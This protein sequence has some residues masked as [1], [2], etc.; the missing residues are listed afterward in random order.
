[1]AAI[2]MGNLK[3]N[4]ITLDKYK[5]SDRALGTMNIRS[6]VEKEEPIKGTEK[7]KSQ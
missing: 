2:S 3:M 7:R 1:M 5:K 6:L 4:K